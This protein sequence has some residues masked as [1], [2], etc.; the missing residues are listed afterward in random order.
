MSLGVSKNQHTT[1]HYPEKN[2]E[3]LNWSRIFQ[4]EYT[5]RGKCLKKLLTAHLELDTIHSSQQ[6]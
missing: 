5:V 4:M 6:L 2:K 1:V 3:V